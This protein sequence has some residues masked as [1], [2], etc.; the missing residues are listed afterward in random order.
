[1]SSIMFSRQQSGIFEVEVKCTN[2]CPSSNDLNPHVDVANQTFLV[3]TV[4]CSNPPPNKYQNT[5]HI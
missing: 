1:M 3:F 5:C 4:M 2:Q